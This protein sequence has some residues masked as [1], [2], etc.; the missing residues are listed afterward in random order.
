M[1]TLYL[2]AP[3]S[4]NEQA[5]PQLDSVMEIMEALPQ[6]TVLAGPYKILETIEAGTFRGHDLALDQIVTVRQGSLK[7]QGGAE[8]WHQK[9]HQ[10]ALIRDSDLLNVLDVVSENSKKSIITERP[11]GRSVADFSGE[12][13]SLPW[14][15]GA[16][17]LQATT[18]TA[19]KDS[20]ALR[21]TQ[22][23]I[24]K[25][26]RD[27]GRVATAVLVMVIF[28]AVGLAMQ[29]K[30][31]QLKARDLDNVPFS[32]GVDRWAIQRPYNIAPPP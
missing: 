3:S 22:E 18:L 2:T 21:Q 20:V 26:D 24:R 31:P 9:A 13:S 6:K 11:R 5:N 29:I 32:R 30:E 14:V 12:R 7:V 4:R 17:A 23:V 28:G 15:E 16:R 10:V 19:R 1:R 8:F 25:F 27:T